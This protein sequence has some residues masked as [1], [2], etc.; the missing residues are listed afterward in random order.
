[1]TR[2]K[3]E[4]TPHQVDRDYPH[5][6]EIAIPSGGLG[7]LL[8]AMHDF[9]PRRRPSDARHRREARRDWPGCRA[10]LLQGARVGRSV[11]ERFGGDRL[12]S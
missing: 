12:D 9:L 11:S 2:R 6:V 8:N 4:I 10:L 3:G 5:Q 7:P 1:M